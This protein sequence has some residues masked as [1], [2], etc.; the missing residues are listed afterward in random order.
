VLENAGADADPCEVLSSFARAFV[1]FAEKSIAGHIA[2][3]MHAR[4]AP[5]TLPFDVNSPDSPP[6]RG[7]AA[8]EAY[9]R[10]ATAAGRMRVTDPR[11]AALLFAGQLQSYVFLHHILRIAPA[12]H[13]FERYLD[14]LLDL[15]TSGLIVPAAAKKRAVKTRG[16][17]RG[18]RKT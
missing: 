10:Q 16:G 6:R 12:P 4:S 14:Q 17:S 18:P 3:Y 9:M 7:I 13:P 15:W 2:V 11:A 5:L 8:L 1:P